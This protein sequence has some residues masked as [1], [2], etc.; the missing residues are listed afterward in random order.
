MSD[1]VLKRVTI[2][3]VETAERCTDLPLQLDLR[4]LANE[5]VDLIEGS[6]PSQPAASF[7][8]DLHARDLTSDTEYGRPGHDDGG[9]VASSTVRDGEPGAHT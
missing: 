8:T 3:L 5:L 1:E 7:G 6:G 4:K 9:R 2:R